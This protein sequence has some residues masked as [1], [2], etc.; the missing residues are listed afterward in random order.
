MK[1]PGLKNKF[2][3]A[4]LS[5]LAM[6]GALTSCNLRPAA[7]PAPDTQILIDSTWSIKNAE[8]SGGNKDWKARQD[9]YLKDSFLKAGY[10]TWLLQLDGLKELPLLEQVEKVNDLVNARVT[11]TDDLS[12]YNSFEYY[13]SGV[14]TML[15][16]KGDC[17]DF[18]IAKFC[19]LR[20]LGVPEN[21]LAILGVATNPLDSVMRQPSHGVLA[22]DTSAAN[23]W[24]NALILNDNEELPST[25]KTLGETG[26]TPCLLFNDK[27][28]R[29]CVV[30]VRKPPAP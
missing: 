30:K 25:V 16:G 7:P 8:L 2:R 27:E 1:F 6:L 9:F 11:W 17:E 20:H 21:R 13:A 15:T 29:I 5:G 22:L 19:A 18:A 3:T 24:T 23:N 10:Q 14:E 26:F 28:L 12:N 4:V